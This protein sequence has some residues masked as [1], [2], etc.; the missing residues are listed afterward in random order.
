MFTEHPVIDFMPDQREHGGQG[1]HDAPWPLPGQAD[2]RLEGRARSTARRSS[3]SA[4]ATASR[5]TTATARRSRRPACCC[6]ASR[7][8]AGSWRS[9]SSR[10]PV[11]RGQP[12]PPGVQV[13]GRSGRT[14][15]STGSSRHR[16]AVAD[17]REPVVPARARPTARRRAAADGGDAMSS[18]PSP[19]P[20]PRPVAVPRPVEPSTASGASDPGGAALGGRRLVTDEL[21]LPLTAGYPGERHGGRGSASPSILAA[22]ART[23]P[24]GALRGLIGLRL[25]G[26]RVPRPHPGLRRGVPRHRGSHA[27]TVWGAVALR[28]RAVL[29]W[30]RS[31][32][33]RLGHGLPRSIAVALLAAALIAEGVVG[34]RCPR[35]LARR[36]AA[37]NPG[38][39]CSPPRRASGSSCR[40]SRSAG[41]AAPSVTSAAPAS[42]P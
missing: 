42:R 20:D 19:A 6:P 24:T 28:R 36:P 8:T 1:R 22:S 34:R 15:C 10:P 9:S 13:A 26:R 17:G 29:G 4:T 39:L 37:H 12:V 27:A 23:V 11:V 5:S 35:W 2:A 16:I 32:I 31:G 7:R 41:G 25:G 40:G 3:T 30:R 21:G 14:R 33:W 18:S 38:F